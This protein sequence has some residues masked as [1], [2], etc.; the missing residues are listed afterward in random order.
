MACM[1]FQERNKEEKNNWEK[2]YL[3]KGYHIMLVYPTI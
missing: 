2:Q 3:R 1:Q